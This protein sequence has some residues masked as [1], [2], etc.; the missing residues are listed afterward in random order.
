VFYVLCSVILLVVCLSVFSVG[1]QMKKQ[2]EVDGD[3]ERHDL[4]AALKWGSVL[5]FVVIFGLWSIQRSFHSVAAGHV[6]VV[7]QFGNI[8]GQTDAGLVTTLPWQKLVEANTQVQRASFDELDSFTS[9]TQDV[10]IKATINYE[11]SPSD[12]QD[13]Y[14]NVGP[15]Y[16]DKLV[17][18][19]LNQIFKDETVKYTAIQIAPNRE[20]IRKNVLKALKAELAPF[21]I[22]IDDLLVDNIKFSPEFT[23]AI[24]DK[25]IATQEAKAAQN[26]V[27]TANAEAKQAIALARGQAKAQRLQRQTLTP[28]LIQ[29]YAID[30]LNPNVQVVLLPAGSN[31]LLPSSLLG[32]GK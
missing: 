18:T 26:R 28:L 31:F 6:G 4:G 15:G 8:V 19:R 2:A 17:P 12:I 29:K 3:K 21:S 7:Y 16:F 5:V 9:E 11:V 27:R 14:R 10:F 24:E 30:K 25:Q 1:R 22:Q 20:R 32:Q 23:K 13:L